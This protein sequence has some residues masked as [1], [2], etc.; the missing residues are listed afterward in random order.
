[1]QRYELDSYYPLFN[2]NGD[3]NCQQN[4]SPST[5]ITTTSNTATYINL[6]SKRLKLNSN[7]ACLS[8]N[9]IA[10]MP[11]TNSTSDD[12]KL[13]NTTMH[14]NSIDFN[15]IDYNSNNN[16]TNNFNN[17]NKQVFHNSNAIQH[18][19]NAYPIQSNVS[20]QPPPTS[21]QAFYNN[22]N[23]NVPQQ[24]QQTFVQMSST[25]NSYTNG[26]QFDFK[27]QQEIKPKIN[28]LSYAS[29][30]KEIQNYEDF[31]SDEDDDEDED[32]EDDEED[33]EDE[34]DEDEDEDEDLGTLKHQ[35]KKSKKQHID[36]ENDYEIKHNCLTED[37]AYM[38]TLFNSPS[39]LSSS[40]TSV[41]NNNSQ[42][43][44]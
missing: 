25:P 36:N 12:V 21:Y 20:V 44:E 1:M 3:L 18:Q 23:N 24:Q 11:A 34:D 2:Q 31:V 4:Q 32:D 33:E 17:N 38:N 10:I 6:N 14:N 22:T 35:H 7:D 19:A 43:L 26:Q 28:K 29:N 5:T 30:K 13:V 27:N 15:L 9:S 40:S 37:G 41:L 16:M 39:S 42:H 8:D